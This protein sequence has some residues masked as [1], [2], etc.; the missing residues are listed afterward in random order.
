MVP[1][2]WPDSTIVILANG[3]S[4]TQADVDQC[5]GHKVIAIKNAIEKA[6]WAD[7][8]YACDRKWWAAHPET[9]NFIGLKYGLERVR[10][11][12]DVVTLQNTGKDGLE[13]DPG[14]LRT[15][16]NSGFQAVNLAVHL[17]ARLIVLLGFDMHADAKGRHHW[18]GWHP[19]GQTIPPYALFLS[20]FPSLVKPL[21]ALGIDVVNC[22]PGSALTCFPMGDLRQTLV[23]DKA[24]AC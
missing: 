23:C 8:L 15:G 16:C 18:H 24:V 14:G 11:R 22:T 19:Y 13:R 3:P 21:K 6:P 9:Q 12:E 1:R 2:L 5:R 10:G 20:H 17:G 7:V 4:L